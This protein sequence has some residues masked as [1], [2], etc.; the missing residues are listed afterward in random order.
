MAKKQKPAGDGRAVGLAE[1]D[2]DGRA[3]RQKG[4]GFGHDTLLDEMRPLRRGVR[5]CGRM[6]RASVSAVPRDRQL[7]IAKRT[8]G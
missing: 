4:F 1:A 2:V 3:G 5:A 6:Q 7:I 8:I